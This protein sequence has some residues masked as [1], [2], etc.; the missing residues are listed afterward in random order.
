[1]SN[2]LI[3]E[4]PLQVLPSLAKKIGLNE[5]IVLQQV[6]YWLEIKKSTKKDYHDGAYWVYNTYDDWK[7]QF[8]FWS[9]ATIRRT[10]SSL[11]KK[12]L[13]ITG[14]YNRAGFDKTKWYTI[15]YEA[16]NSLDNASAQ[17]EHIVCS[18]GTDGD[19]QIEQNNTRENLKTIPETIIL[20]GKKPNTFSVRK[21]FDSEILRKQIQKSCKE[22]GI[23][24]ASF[25]ID[26]IQYYYEMYAWR[27]GKEH[28]RLSSN[29]M[30]DVVS[31]ISWGTELIVDADSEMYRDMIDKHF[32]TQ[33]NDCDYNICH[34]VSGAIRDHRFYEVC[35]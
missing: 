33:Y 32:D 1:M 23:E 7:K 6:H 35:Y 29:A 20:K 17:N 3:N 14:N 13:L 16:L 22:L 28:P 8:D 10:F 5:A 27:F 34:F 30:N 31:A 15:N 12:G 21:S 11:E 26:V 9:I 2:L 4:P 18:D 25:C 19:V 24:D